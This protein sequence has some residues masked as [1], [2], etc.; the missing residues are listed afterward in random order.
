[1]SPMPSAFMTTFGK[2]ICMTKRSGM[3][4]GLA[5]IWSY[6]Q[7]EKQPLQSR[8][9][10]FFWLRFHC[11]RHMHLPGSR[12]DGSVES[13]QTPSIVGGSTLLRL[14][15]RG[16]VRL[17]GRICTSDGPL[18]ELLKKDAKFQR[19]A[20]RQAAFEEVKAIL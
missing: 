1:M 8:S 9:S 16:K 2:S 13:S 11:Q 5:G 19:T 15:C 7:S 17:R 4:S 6:A 3:C 14:H 10:Y 20:Q 12:K 18:R